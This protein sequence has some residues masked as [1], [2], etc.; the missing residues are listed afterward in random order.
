MFLC[1]SC[2]L[3]FTLV[4][5]CISKHLRV[6]VKLTQPYLDSYKPLLSPYLMLSTFNIFFSGQISVPL[7]VWDFAV[8][9]GKMFSKRMHTYRVVKINNI[10]VPLGW[11]SHVAILFFNI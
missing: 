6:L 4:H 7:Y 9:A 11:T 3:E 2:D 1:L 5:H 10:S 8:K